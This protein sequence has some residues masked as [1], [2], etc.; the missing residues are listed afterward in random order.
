MIE[1]LDTRVQRMLTAIDDVTPLA[2][3]L[4]ALVARTA[5]SQPSRSTPQRFLRA[6]LL[7]TAG[8]AIGATLIIAID[9]NDPVPNDLPGTK[10][11]TVESPTDVS[12]TPTGPSTTEVPP[13]SPP[14]APSPIAVSISDS[15]LQQPVKAVALQ[16]YSWSENGEPSSGLAR[17]DFF[18]W[19][20]AV[21]ALLPTVPVASPIIV[22]LGSNDAQG[23]TNP[24]G[25]V[26]GFDDP[27][28]GRSNT[29]DGFVDLDDVGVERDPVHD[30]SDEAGIGDDR[31]CP[32]CRSP[33][34]NPATIC[35]H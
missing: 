22:E 27:Q 3:E 23:L 34:F 24:D 9:R 25:T 4:D 11:P 28:Y 21:D 33:S 26:I 6:A 20:A 10:N 17:P 7:V 18:D 8:I 5:P 16:G 2:P 15:T 30:R 19:P 1:D 32:T 14:F 35:E 29:V 12:A 13:M 31:L